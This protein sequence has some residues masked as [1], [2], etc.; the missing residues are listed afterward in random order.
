MRLMSQSCDCALITI[1]FQMLKQCGF[2]DFEF[3]RYAQNVYFAQLL[4]RHGFD[5]RFHQCW[6]KYVG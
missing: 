6:K 4:L 5:A 2:K 1:S 3:F